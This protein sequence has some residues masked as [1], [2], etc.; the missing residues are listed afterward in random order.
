MSLAPEIL[1]SAEQAQSRI[2]P[3]AASV[4]QIRQERDQLRAALRWIG[5]IDHCAPGEILLRTALD[6]LP[7]GARIDPP[8]LDDYNR[9]TRLLRAQPWVRRGF[10]RLGRDSDEWATAAEVLCVQAGLPQPQAG[11]LL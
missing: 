5:G 10:I 3:M 8:G 9:L 6:A 11:E 7:L 4:L 2:P 1:L